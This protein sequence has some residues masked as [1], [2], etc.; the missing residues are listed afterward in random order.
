[1]TKNTGDNYWLRKQAARRMSRRSWLGGATAATVGASAFALV[2]CGDDDKSSA[3]PTSGN[4][5]PTSGATG[6]ASAAATS[7]N[8]PKQGGDIRVAVDRDPVSFDPHIEASYR[9]QWAIGGAYNRVLSL[10]SDLKIGPELAKSQ[11]QVD[12]TTLILHVQEGVKFHNVDPV[13]GRAMTADD[14]KWSLDRI[15]TDQ[16][17]FQRQYMFEAI[18]SMEVVDPNTLKLV[19]KQPFAPLQAYLANP[20]TCV[21]PH[22][23][24]DAEG[25]LRTKAIGTGPFI[26]QDAQKG[27]GYKSVRNPDYWESGMPYLDSYNLAVM[28]DDSSRVSAFKAKQLDLELMSPDDANGFKSDKSVTVGESA[29][30][31]WFSL[32]Y[33]CTKAP[34]ND[35]RA[36]QALD[37]CLDRKQII[38]LTLGGVGSAMG[39]I[40]PGLADWALPESEL[41]KLPSY[42]SDKS[43][44]IKNAKQLLDSAGLADTEFEYLFYTPAAINEQVAVVVQQQLQAAGI[45]V[46]LNKQ[47][48]AAWIPL[49][50]EGNYM[51]TGTSSGFRDNPD[52][53]LYALFF[54]GAS[55][56]DTGYTNPD[57]DKQLELQRTQLDEAQRKQTVN[58]LQ[59]KLL[60]EV[61]NSWIY[62]ELVMEPRYSYVAGFTPTYQHNRTRQFVRTWF[63]R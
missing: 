58:D 22:E 37:L 47:E 31:G 62:E 39:P 32:R 43:E 17:E 63:D 54:T 42:R 7:G 53:Y 6:T 5:Q 30:G 56:N 28:A 60:N 1:M 8:A 11:E 41:S 15:R 57:L 33:N 24:V 9:T 16:P 35:V 26:L 21:A 50:L 38:D 34:F 13:N 12:D 14:I 49:T 27:V 3:T 19:L 51:L 23:V 29:Q 61:P 18:D 36:R 55:R 20:F 59:K 48:Y 25:D 46:K 40:A 45:K 44:D 10:S 52:E 4:A 2:G